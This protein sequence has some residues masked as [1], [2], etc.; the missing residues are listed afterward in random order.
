[1]P[2]AQFLIAA[3][4]Q[5]AFE[6]AYEQAADDAVRYGLAQ[7]VKKLTLPDQMGERFQA[8]L[9]ARSMPALP[10]PEALLDADQ[11]ERL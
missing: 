2:Q 1:V 9:F 8:M 11:G 5:Q 3:G 7:Q 4:L 6:Q 10:V